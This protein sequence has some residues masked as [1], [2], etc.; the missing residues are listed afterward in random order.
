MVEDVRRARL[1]QQRPETR[2]FSPTTLRGRPVGTCGRTD[3]R[4]ATSGFGMAIALRLS[5][6]CR[7]RCLVRCRHAAPACL[8]L[9][10]AAWAKPP[11]WTAPHSGTN[12]TRACIQPACLLV[13][14]SPSSPRAAAAA[15]GTVAAAVT[16]AGTAAA[17]AVQQLGHHAQRLLEGSVV[18]RHII[19][20]PAWVQRMIGDYC[21]GTKACWPGHHSEPWCACPVI[22]K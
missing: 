15:V 4:A 16:A 22:L 7:R 14:L 8:Q 21:G 10:S 6:M 19:L 18:P 1:G 5:C 17:A 2:L 9:P 3:L 13:W 20:L 12:I 11:S